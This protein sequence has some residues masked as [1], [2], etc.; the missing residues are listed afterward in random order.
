MLP[1]HTHHTIFVVVPDAY[2]YEPFAG[3]SPPISVEAKGIGVSN[4]RP[5]LIAFSVKN[6]GRNLQLPVDRKGFNITVSWEAS[7]QTGVSGYDRHETAAAAAQ[8]HSR[9]ARGLRATLFAK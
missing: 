5:L 8:G 4:D 1:H 2:P 9:G 7:V 3:Y 6:N